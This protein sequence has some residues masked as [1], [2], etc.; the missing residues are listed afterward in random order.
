MDID[1]CFVVGM[2]ETSWRFRCVWMERLSFL[3]EGGLKYFEWQKE[4]PHSWAA[5]FK[6]AFQSCKFSGACSLA[7]PR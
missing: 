6:F 2:N 5:V 7:L 3:E 4:T 1:F